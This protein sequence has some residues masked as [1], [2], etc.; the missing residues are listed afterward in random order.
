VGDAFAIRAARP[1]L[2]FV[3]A[4]TVGVMTA[5]FPVCKRGLAVNLAASLARDPAR[6]ARVCVV[7][8]DPSSLDVSTRLAVPGPC[9][10]DF[11]GP[12]LPRTDA[13][14]AVHEPPLWVVP[15]AETGVES[16]E[17]AADLALPRLA[18]DFDLVICDLAMPSVLDGR[19]GAVR[20]VDR[21]DW[22][23]V[24]V[25]PDVEPVEATA[26]CLDRIEEMQERGAIAGSV[27]IGVV[28]TGDEGST[29]LSAE[30]VGKALR[31]PVIGSVRQL[32]GRTPPN[33]GFG[34]ALGIAELDDGV[35]LLFGR[36]GAPAAANACASRAL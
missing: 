30:V 3:T 17:R 18:R 11:A 10:E 12:V 25:T 27:R 19:P 36:L 21:M 26:R 23:L 33:L 29:D 6:Q 28:T 2:G 20:V 5:R 13:L 9:L 34:A 1:I 32:W 7:D 35:S 8:A 14:G 16:A 22:L 24:A 15:S 4:L 31:R